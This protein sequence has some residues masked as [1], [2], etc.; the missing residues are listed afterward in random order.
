MA[1]DARTVPVQAYD[2]L[3]HHGAGTLVGRCQRINES[4]DVTLRPV[5]RHLQGRRIDVIHVS[6]C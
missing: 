3:P 4:F 1:D 2:G 6:P 5:D